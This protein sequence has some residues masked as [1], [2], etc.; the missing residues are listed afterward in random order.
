MQKISTGVT[1]RYIDV[2]AKELGPSKEFVH[3]NIII[4]DGAHVPRVGE[5]VELMHW[6][7]NRDMKFGVYI[8]L[9]AHTRIALFDSNDSPSA[10]H[11]TLTVG[12]MP[13]GIDERFIT[14]GS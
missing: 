8:V 7:N 2:G 12:P 11:T 14:Q 1:F 6:D 10:W 9:F 3:Q 13:E 5:A 4:P